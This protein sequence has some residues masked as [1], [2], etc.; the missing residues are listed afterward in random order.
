M[1]PK[2]PLPVRATP[3]LALSVKVAVVFNRPPLLKVIFPAVAAV[4]AVPS[5]RSSLIWRRPPRICVRP[6]KV[7]FCSKSMRPAPVFSMPKPPAD[8]VM[9]ALTRRSTAAVPSATSKMERLF[10]LLSRN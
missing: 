3:R 7:L 4:G 5:R 10:V 9:N 6:L 2:P 1:T 8:S